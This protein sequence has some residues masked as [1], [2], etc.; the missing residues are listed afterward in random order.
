MSEF[1]SVLRMNNNT[2]L[3][4]YTLFC[5]SIHLVVNTGLV[6]PPG[7]CIQCC[8]EHG[9]C[10][11]MHLCAT[12]V[13]GDDSFPFGDHGATVIH[14]AQAVA[15]PASSFTVKTL[16]GPGLPGRVYCSNL[17]RNWLQQLSDSLTFNR[18]RCHQMQPMNYS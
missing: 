13:C 11:A 14:E 16:M 5:L 9:G 18:S 17:G 10:N 3:Q 6:L 7:Y 1:F 2:L 4:V 15:C 12:W 8:Y